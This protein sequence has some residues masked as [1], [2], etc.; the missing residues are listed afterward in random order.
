[1]DD[2]SDSDQSENLR[3]PASLDVEWAG[4]IMD[5]RN[6]YVSTYRGYEMVLPNSQK[7]YYTNLFKVVAILSISDI[8]I[9]VF[10]C[11]H[12]MRVMLSDG[13]LQASEYFNGIDIAFIHYML[14]LK[15]PIH[16]QCYTQDS[17]FILL[18]D[19]WKSL[20]DSK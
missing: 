8:C 2:E 16:F 7:Y 5:T 3:S 14:G 18:V 4:D 10:P 11:D 20:K 12:Y 15:I 1:M 19:A 17:R 6:T 9:E 13:T